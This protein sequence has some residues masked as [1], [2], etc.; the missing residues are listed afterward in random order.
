LRLSPKFQLNISHGGQVTDFLVFLV[1]SVSETLLTL[2][3]C[4]CSL[5]IPFFITVCI[6]SRKLSLS[7]ILGL[8][9]NNARA[10]FLSFIFLSAWKFVWFI[11]I[12]SKNFIVPGGLSFSPLLSFQLEKLQNWSKGYLRLSQKFWL[13]ISHGGQVIECFMFSLFCQSVRLLLTFHMCICFLC[14]P[15]FIT[16]CIF[17]RK[18]SLSFILGLLS[19]VARASFLS[20]IFY[21]RWKISMICFNSQ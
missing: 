21:F 6:F 19:N 18:F 11:F 1:L 17:C 5:C 2:H 15:F 7:F 3:L 14:I 10:S 13:I 20:Y 4:I 12:A 8:L 9:Y 16:I